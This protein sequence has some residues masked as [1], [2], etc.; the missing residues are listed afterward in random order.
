MAASGHP[1]GALR[2]GQN[3]PG[4]QAG[5]P[6]SPARVRAMPERFVW[7]ESPKNRFI[8]KE[9]GKHH[10]K[11]QASVVRRGRKTRFQGQRH[12][13]GQGE[14]KKRLCEPLARSAG[15]AALNLSWSSEK[16][17]TFNGWANLTR[18]AT[19]PRPSPARGAIRHLSSGMQAAGRFASL[20]AP[21]T[22]G[23]G[24]SKGI[25]GR[26][27]PSPSRPVSSLRCGPRQPG[28]RPLTPFPLENRGGPRR[29]GRNSSFLC[30]VVVI[31]VV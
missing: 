26:A 5:R 25:K 10:R 18:R 21:Q 1:C 24:R 20:T 3:A 17:R 23:L 8:R 29:P 16:W 7:F 6:L 30:G 19:P 9:G 13:Q 4:R 22:R 15:F 2:P 31:V 28:F 11:K 27:S 14:T 12:R